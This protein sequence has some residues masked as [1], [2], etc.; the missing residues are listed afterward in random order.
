MRQI[1]QRKRLMHNDCAVALL[2][3]A[4]EKIHECPVA[5][6][7]TPSHNTGDR[8]ILRASGIRDAK[9]PPENEGK[10]IRPVIALAGIGSEMVGATLAGVLLDWLMGSLP[11]FT[12]LFTVLGLAL[13]MWHLSKWAK[14]RSLP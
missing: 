12:G 8:L 1:S 3:Q 11:V 4:C 7:R 6:P 5:T 10:R 14:S 2:Q 9:M 13:A